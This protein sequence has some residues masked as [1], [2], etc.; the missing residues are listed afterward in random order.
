MV[1][2]AVL[3][4]PWPTIIFLG[5]DCAWQHDAEAAAWGL[6]RGVALPRFDSLFHGTRI[7]ADGV[8]LPDGVWALAAPIARAAMGRDGQPFFV[9]ALPEVF[10]RALPSRDT[11]DLALRLQSVA[12][13]ELLHTIQL[14]DFRSALRRRVPENQR[15]ARLDDNMIE[16][17]FRADSDFTASVRTEAALLYEAARTASAERATFL[18]DSAVRLMRRGQ[19][20]HFTA[21]YASYGRIDELFLNM[22][23]VAEYVRLRFHEISQ[24]PPGIADRAALVDWIR[25]L[26]NDWVQDLGFGLVL[27][28]DRLRPRCVEHLVLDIMPS[29]LEVLEYIITHPESTS[30]APS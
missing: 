5:V 25:G 27:V 20:R 3:A 30:G 1:F 14:G 12:S 21:Q 23:G 24:M 17:E 7:P 4:T 10:A 19:A 2:P 13:H 11:V 8:L 28:I 15:P 22:E 18:A 9:M 26:D 16:R 29:P 6:A